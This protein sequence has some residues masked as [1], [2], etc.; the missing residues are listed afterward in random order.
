[1]A[2][3]GDCCMGSSPAEAAAGRFYAVRPP[4]D[5]TADEDQLKAS[6]RSYDRK[7][8]PF[9]TLAPLH[10]SL[11]YDMGEAEMQAAMEPLQRE[12][13]T[14]SIMGREIKKK[15]GEP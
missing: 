11:L 3:V 5:F 2:F 6:W 14:P 4:W 12:E 9:R 8:L 15:S 13:L 7:R 10:N 1:M